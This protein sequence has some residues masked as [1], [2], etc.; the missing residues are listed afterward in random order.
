M[1]RVRVQEDPKYGLTHKTGSISFD[2]GVRGRELERELLAAAIKF[3]RDM[4]LRGLILYKVPGMQNPTWVR[5][6]DGQYAAWY[7][8]DWEGKRPRK[9]AVTGGGEITLPTT[10]E[11]SLEDSQGEV[12]Y[13]IVGI[14]WAPERAIEILTSVA[15]RKDREQR[16]RHPQSFTIDTPFNPNLR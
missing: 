14:F 1:A 10:R 9:H 16:E 5:N 11:R 6:P 8:I 3:I 13:R 2:A 7:A 12:E 4:E 15:E